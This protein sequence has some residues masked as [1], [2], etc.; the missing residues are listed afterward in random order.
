MAGIDSVFAPVEG[1]LVRLE[2]IPDPTF[3]QKLMGDGIAI[4][5]TDG[6]VVSPIDGEVILVSDTKHAIG[7]KGKSGI[8][9]LIHIGLETVALKGEGF[10]VH[11]KQGDCVK[12]GDPLITFDLGIIKEKAKSTVT[13]VIVTNSDQFS[14]SGKT[15]E[16]TVH[17]NETVLFTAEAKTMLPGSTPVRR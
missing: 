4:E 16:N 8:E 15:R 2:D 11:V 1:K 5:P 13:P 10:D 9:L 17:R 6:K 12:K 14:V 3:S 7:L